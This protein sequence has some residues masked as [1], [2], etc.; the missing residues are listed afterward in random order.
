MRI[1]CGDSCCNDMSRQNKRT[2]HPQR[3]LAPSSRSRSRTSLPD[4]NQRIDLSSTFPAIGASNQHHGPHP[5][6]ETAWE[7][8]SLQRG[9]SSDLTHTGGIPQTEHFQSLYQ[10]AP[11]A[12]SQ[13]LTQHQA[14]HSSPRDSQSELPSSA[15]SLIQPGPRVILPPPHLQAHPT[16]RSDDQI[17]REMKPQRL[18]A[19]ADPFYSP[20]ADPAT[21]EGMISTP[22]NQAVSEIARNTQQEDS[23]D[24]NFLTAW[25]TF[26]S[27]NPDWLISRG[28]PGGN[29]L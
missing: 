4:D 16:T 7:P 11:G 8:V 26:T 28:V 22:I 19:E 12:G 10:S 3:E 15:I 29:I 5:A 9:D 21:P 24:P 2:H 6:S 25:G 20:F 27:T 18:R 23:V 14:S 17:N 13:L 1:E